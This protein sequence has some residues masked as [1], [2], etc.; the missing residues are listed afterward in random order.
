MK[1]RL[2]HVVATPFPANQG[3]AAAARELINALSKRGHEIH[4]VT[5]YQGQDGELPGVYMHRIPRLGR[6]DESFVGFTK[7]RPLLDI[8]LA[9]KT[10]QVVR[11]VRPH[12][13]HAHHHEGVLAAF[14]SRFITGIPVLYHCVASMEEE[15]PLFIRPKS[16]M[17]RLG[18]L[19]DVFIPDLADCCGVA[20]PD[21]VNSICRNGSF[22]KQVFDL[23]TIVDVSTFAKGDGI[24]FRRNS[25]MINDPMVLYTG[26][27]N[28]FQGIDNLLRAMTVVADRMPS[29][30]LVVAASLSNEIQVA[31]YETLA[32]ELGLKN[33]VV[34]LKGFPF[35][36]LPHLLAAADV[37]VMPREKCAGFPIK[38]LNY[39][40]AGKPI[41]A[42]R[43][44]AKILREGKN[45]L[46]ADTWEEL[47]EKIVMLLRNKELSKG[48]GEAGRS[49]L[50]WFAP[51]AVVEKTEQIYLS[52]IRNS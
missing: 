21:L 24:K 22:H 36:E 33:N 31:K 35:N 51:D 27:I 42:M 20:S 45:G 6:S 52:L 29:A 7:K 2:V 32:N 23:P 43:G 12:V 25:G 10:L 13:I 39:M 38:L 30:K 40:A 34:F 5:Y 44:T 18:G 3:T 47:G 17:Q 50:G 28:E 15:L 19:L 49:E 1:L 46:V 37:T 4:V 26:V 9:F 16:I 14:P 11:K 48:L 41:V 8:A